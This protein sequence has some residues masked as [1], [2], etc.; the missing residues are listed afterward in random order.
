[1]DVTECEILRRHDQ[2]TK[3][4]QW[5]TALAKGPNETRGKTLKTTFFSDGGQTEVKLELV[6]KKGNPL[7]GGHNC[8]G[9]EADGQKGCRIGQGWRESMLPSPK[10]GKSHRKKSSCQKACLLKA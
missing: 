7:A 2:K 6:G 5:A 4:K 3:K 9:G 10:W 1:V 8:H